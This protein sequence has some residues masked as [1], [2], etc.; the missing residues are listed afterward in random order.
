MFS[1]IASVKLGSTVQPFLFQPGAQLDSNSKRM[2]MNEN[3]IIS[4]NLMNAHQS[5]D[6]TASYKVNIEYIN[7][8]YYL[9]NCKDIS[10]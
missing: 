10:R 5:V 3:S 7:R 8:I 2:R 4:G 6:S 1:D 9:I